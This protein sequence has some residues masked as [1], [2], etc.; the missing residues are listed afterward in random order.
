MFQP[1]HYTIALLFMLLSMVCWGSWANTLKMTPQWPFQLFYL[2]YVAGLVLTM[3]AWGCTLG[4]LFGGPTAFWQ[5]LRS[6]DASHIGLAL[7]AGIIFNLANVLLVAAIEIAGLAVAFPLGIGL[8]LVVGVFINFVISPQGNPILLFGGVALVLVAIVID[9]AA[10][11]KREST[12]AKATRRGILLSLTCGC[13]MGSFYPFVASAS[14]GTSSLGPY[15]VAFV[16]GMGVLLC[17]LPLNALVMANPLTTAA[18][19]RW[20]AYGG[21]SIKFHLWGLVGGSIWATGAV[22]N[23]A[24][25]HSLI[26]GPAVSYA[27]GQGATM[28]S[29]VWGVFVWRE[30]HGAPKSA[31]RLLPLMF[32]FFLAGLVMVALAPLY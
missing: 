29:A 20:R 3:L 18:P 17:A 10:Y 15:T 13:L 27:I 24:A 26:V 6:A 16:F 21:G 28:V 25:S 14:R 1:E 11:S 7:L 12:N 22:L 32:L 9:A 2:D 19:V 23:F 30:F 31:K 5:N 4:N 8:A